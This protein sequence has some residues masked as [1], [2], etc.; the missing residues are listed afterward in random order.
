MK[1]KIIMKRAKCERCAYMFSEIE[2]NEFYNHVNFCRGLR[3]DTIIDRLLLKALRTYCFVFN[4]FYEHIHI[5]KG[6]SW[7]DSI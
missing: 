1:N 5:F 6:K 3:Q 4:F 2:R 7:R